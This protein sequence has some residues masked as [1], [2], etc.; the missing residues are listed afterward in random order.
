VLV[1]E[2][3][4]IPVPFHQQT[5]HDDMIIRFHDGQTV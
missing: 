4:H 1:T 2:P 3:R 5:Q